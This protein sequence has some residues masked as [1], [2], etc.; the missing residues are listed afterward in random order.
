MAIEGD[1]LPTPTRKQVRDRVKL[2]VEEWLPFIRTLRAAATMIVPPTPPRGLA[3]MI[4][5]P[6]N[7]S[8]LPAPAGCPLKNRL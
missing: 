3:A 8:F 7:S 6:G 1:A 2:D 5:F 4:L